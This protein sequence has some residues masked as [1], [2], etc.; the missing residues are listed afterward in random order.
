MSTTRQ[1][2]KT[3]IRNFTSQGKP[4]CYSNY[5]LA[6]KLRKAE[7]TTA[8][9]LSSMKRAGEIEVYY[10]GKVRYL[11]LVPKIKNIIPDAV[12]KFYA[13]KETK[14]GQNLGTKSGKPIYNINISKA[15]ASS[16][17]HII[18]ESIDITL[19]NEIRKAAPD[20]KLKQL[21]K[22]VCS[23]N[24]NILK[25]TLKEFKVN[26]KVKKPAGL[27]THN[28]YE[29]IE[30]EKEKAAAIKLEQTRKEQKLKVQHK[31]KLELQKKQE[32][33]EIQNSH[34]F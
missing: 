9:T 16:N 11:K 18:T 27:F 6:A 31:K 32:E 12:K 7:K 15:K 22:L 10:H 4:F 17:I 28:V 20:F 33:S 23:V 5:T 8:N 13:E 21:E 19:V 24:S 34:P 29:N 2:I 26:E 1:S 25:K 3:M 30:L 14:K